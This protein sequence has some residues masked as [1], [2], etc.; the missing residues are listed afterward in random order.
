[1][2]FPFLICSVI[3]PDPALNQPTQSDCLDFVLCILFSYTPLFLPLLKGVFYQNQLFFFFLFVTLQKLTCSSNF[4]SLFGVQHSLSA[5]K[6]VICLIQVRNL[7][8]MYSAASHKRNLMMLN[9]IFLVFQFGET[10]SRRFPWMAGKSESVL[11]S[12]F[13]LQMNLG[14]V[15][16]GGEPL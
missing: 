5:F 2:V 16:S 12:F 11:F 15:D 7:H 1:M 10:W 8:K 13:F 6:F 4:C 9:C 3:V 14:K